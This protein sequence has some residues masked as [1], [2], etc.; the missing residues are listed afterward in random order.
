[1]ILSFIFESRL[2]IA[3]GQRLHLQ[4]E[5]Q[6]L[7]FNHKINVNTYQRLSKVKTTINN[8]QD[9]L[10]VKYNQQTT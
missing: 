8:Y 3:V 4:K 1:M 7:S 10:T 6:P 5:Y 9:P 2:Y